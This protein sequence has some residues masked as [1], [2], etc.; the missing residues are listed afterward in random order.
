[1]A[2]KFLSSG[3]I[4]GE[5][6]IEVA[7]PK[8]QLKPTTQNN[9]SVIELGV[10]NAGTNA[11]AKIDAINLQN[12]DT[13]LRFY[14]NAAGTT[15]QV[16]RMRIGSSLISFPT[17]T[18]LRG[19]I[20]SAKF[21]VGNMGDASSQMMVSSR[22]FITFNVSNTGSGLD[23]LERLRI[24]STGAISVGSTGTNY[25]SSGQVLTSGGNSNPTWTTPTTGTVTG[26]GVATRVA[27]WSS[28]TALSSNANLYW[29]N[30]NS[31]LGIGVSPSYKLQILETG[32]ATTNIGVY[33][34]VQGNGT[35]NYSFYADATQGTSTN[36]AFY[37]A[38]GKSAF[39]NDVGINTDAPTEKLEVKT[40][41]I[42][43]NAEN[44][45]LIVDSVSKRVGFMKYSGHEAYISRV[46]GQDFAIVRTGGTDIKDGSSITKDL[47][48]SGSGDATFGGNV[49]MS[50]A[51]PVLEISSTS[52][53]AAQII[54]GRTADTKAKIKAGDALAGDLTFSTGGSRRIEIANGGGITFNNALTAT[55]ASFSGD[56]NIN[57]GTGYNDKSNIYL[58]NSRTLIQSDIVDQT[59]NG[60]TS[61]DFQTRS[62]GS[63]S[64]AI[65]IDEF[66]RVGIGTTSPTSILQI[67]KSTLPRITLT[68]TGVLDWFIGNPS[69]G[70]SN[71]FTIGTNSGSNDEILTLTNTGNVGIGTTSPNAKLEVASGQAKTVT[72]GVEFAR[73]GTSNEA[74]NY[75]T[76]NC[77]MK[78]GAT[79]ADRKW[80]FQTIEA[81]VANAGN[82]IFQPDG[83]KVGIGTDSPQYKLDIDGQIRAEGIVNIGGLG[84]AASGALA[85]VDINDTD[86]NGT[87][88]TYQSN[89]TFKAAGVLKAQI[90]KLSN[91]TNYF[92]AAKNFD[93]PVNIIASEIHS[94][95]THSQEYIFGY[96]PANSGNTWGLNIVDDTN[97]PN[98]IYIGAEGLHNN[99]SIFFHGY[100]NAL[101]VTR[102]SLNQT[103]GQWLF[104]APD[105][106]TSSTSV[107]WRKY[108]VAGYMQ[109]MINFESSGTINNATGSYGSIS[110]DERVK[111]NI[112]E[113]TSKLD[114][115][116]SLRVKNF[117]FIGDDF[118]Q[119]G[120]IAQEVEEVFPSWVTTSDTRIYKTHDE[121]G[122][123]LEEQ[124]ELV[125]GYEDGKGLKVG[126][127][128]AVLV[129][130]IQ[131]L[132]AKIVALESR[133]NEM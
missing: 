110:S 19:D 115:I 8:L 51:A 9:A 14:T 125:S 74:S 82:I 13:N 78:G 103:L 122:V 49:T 130:T 29:D 43:I 20:G 88:T 105:C 129:K 50:K 27:F 117:N 75:A 24:T 64:S 22:G 53:G 46:A 76:L 102:I 6:K 118:K 17:I 39:L 2:L 60:D 55:T 104:D 112:V 66:R 111:E 68:K 36:F 3:D 38:S 132:N 100:V 21:A 37:A 4:D 62:G 61:L 30:T 44:E 16:E 32:G 106:G 101:C 124:G 89:I 40:G 123:P 54:I 116:L 98:S 94:G 128:F 91:S 31:R 71:N 52:G 120:L 56:I 42:F 84:V 121:H 133:I 73:F 96:E 63:T 59:A 18:E 79:A 90:G 5:F 86:T 114:D 57:G 69:Q 15:A 85:N 127:E 99:S 1:M 28:T 41:S 25:G 48:I 93:G 58:S 80:I 35:N 95:H 83:G 65:F 67:K 34:N 97:T 119:I 108:N 11:Y 126:M 47:D 109:N 23:A 33:S 107:K 131:E 113:A 92:T 70:A 77:E 87:S 7:G 26:T 12:Y 10:L 45:G 72:S 81:G